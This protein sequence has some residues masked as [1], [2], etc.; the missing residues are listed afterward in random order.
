[1]MR[2]SRET[3]AVLTGQ[4][5]RV[6]GFV[7]SDEPGVA[8][9]AVPNDRAQLNPTQ[10]R[11]LAAWANETAAEIERDSGPTARRTGGQFTRQD[12]LNAE[13][14]QIDEALRRARV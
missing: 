6:V 13:R 12:F 1:M 4:A 3:K 7:K 11:E 2:V 5:G 10:L 14:R 8:S 9:L